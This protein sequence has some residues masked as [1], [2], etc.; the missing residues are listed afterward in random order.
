MS[1][2]EVQKDSKIFTGRL[3]ANLLEASC[4]SPSP[5]P[6]P[7]AATNHPHIGD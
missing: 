6:S 2:Y 4:P 3:D 7:S 5:S 1:E